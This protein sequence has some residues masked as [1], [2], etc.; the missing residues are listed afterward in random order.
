M[1]IYQVRSVPVPPVFAFRFFGSTGTVTDAQ[2]LVWNYFHSSAFLEE[3]NP[4]FADDGFTLFSGVDETPQII[5]WT[6]FCTSTNRTQ[7]E[8]KPKQLK[9]I[10]NWEPDDFRLV[11]CFFGGALPCAEFA[12]YEFYVAVVD[13]GMDEDICELLNSVGIEFWDYGSQGNGLQ[14]NLKPYDWEQGLDK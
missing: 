10:G 4:I 8:K 3:W 6:P 2:L 7:L 5:R 11:N 14:W 9:S 13:R 1:A 12:R